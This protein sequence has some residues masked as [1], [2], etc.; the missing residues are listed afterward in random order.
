MS[1]LK[2]R[3]TTDYIRILYFRHERLSHAD[4]HQHFF[5]LADADR[6]AHFDPKV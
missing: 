4:W 3:M 5:D 2:C 6:P 1:I